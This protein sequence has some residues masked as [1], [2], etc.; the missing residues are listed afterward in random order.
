MATHS[1]LRFNYVRLLERSIIGK[2]PHTEI[3]AAMCVNTVL[4]YCPALL[5]HKFP[6]YSMEYLVVQF[7]GQNDFNRNMPHI[8]HFNRN[9][10][11]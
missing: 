10:T 2:N 4:P 8:K 11:H 1:L 3:F 6:E 7:D 5:H 9:I